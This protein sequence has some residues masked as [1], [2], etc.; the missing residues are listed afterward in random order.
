M[1][2][3]I[4]SSTAT[5]VLLAFLSIGAG[6][7]SGQQVFDNFEG[8]GMVSY[9]ITKTAKIDTLAD[10]P[11]TDAVN[12]S[13]KCAKFSRSRQRYDYVKIFPQG[14]LPDISAYASYDANAPKFKLK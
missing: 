5:K 2:T 9:A 13:A 6:T 8:E 14:K 10:N 3:T 1:K 7:A 4:P 11:Q 12:G